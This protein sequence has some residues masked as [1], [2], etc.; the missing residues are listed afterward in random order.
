MSFF[1]GYLF[2]QENQASTVSY[3]TLKKVVSKFKAVLVKFDETYPSNVDKDKQYKQLAAELRFSNDV[4]LA[5]INVPDQ[6]EKSE[7][8]LLAE[9][10][11][12]DNVEEMPFL[13]LF[14]QD[15]FD[16]PIMIPKDLNDPSMIRNYVRSQ[17][18]GV[19]FQLESCI[20]SFDLLANEFVQKSNDND[21]KSILNEAKKSMEKLDENDKQFA[22]VYVKVMERMLERGELFLQSERERVK[23]MLKGKLSDIKKKQFQTKLNILENFQ[24]EQIHLKDEL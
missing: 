14:K 5:E 16:N 21:R 18:S 7:E 15:D 11:K 3:H 13:Y 9:K 20:E 17:V 4:F 23:N 19:R 2:A 8:R 24:I 6:G 22:K 12:A 1:F 10:L